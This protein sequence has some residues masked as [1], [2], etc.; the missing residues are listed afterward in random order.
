MDGGFFSRVDVE[1]DALV[2][3]DSGSL[4]STLR[5]EVGSRKR[6]FGVAWFK[7]CQEAMVISA[8]VLLIY[9]YPGQT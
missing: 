5:E 9:P 8:S 3:A 2:G 7:P 4:A 1:S 6:C